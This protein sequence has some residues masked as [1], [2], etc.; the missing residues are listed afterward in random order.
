M[1]GGKEEPGDIRDGK[2]VDWRNPESEKEF[3]GGPGPFLVVMVAMDIWAPIC[4]CGGR[5]GLLGT[6]GHSMDCEARA[7]QVQGLA[8]TVLMNGRHCTF[9]EDLFEVVEDK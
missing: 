7:P 6:S 1:W 3:G 4:K 5:K 9:S 8:V 2:W